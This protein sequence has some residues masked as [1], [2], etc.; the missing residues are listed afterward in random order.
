MPFLAE[1]HL[2]EHYCGDKKNK[3]K[4]KR[5]EKK[6]LKMPG[7]TKGMYGFYSSPEGFLSLPDSLVSWM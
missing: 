7:N 3:K 5:H 2:Y 1:G 4:K 6:F